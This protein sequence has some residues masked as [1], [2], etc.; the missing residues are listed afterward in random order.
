MQLSRRLAGGSTSSPVALAWRH[1]S[2]FL[3]IR[4]ISNQWL[5]KG[6]AKQVSWGPVSP[7]KW[8][9][10]DTALRVLLLQKEIHIMYMCMCAHGCVCTHTHTHKPTHIYALPRRLYRLPYHATYKCQTWFKMLL[11]CGVERRMIF[12]PENFYFIFLHIL[13]STKSNMAK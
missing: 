8:E 5:G 7:M 3:T 9:Q 12:H 10:L 13:E 2:D 1:I 11:Y 4:N 6:R